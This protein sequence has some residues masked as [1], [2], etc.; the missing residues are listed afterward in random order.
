MV[1]CCGRRSRACTPLRTSRIPAT[2]PSPPRSPCWSRRTPQECLDFAKAGLS[3]SPRSIDTPVLLRLCTRIAHSQSIV[4]IQRAGR[5]LPQKPYIKNGAKYI[6][7]PGNAIPPPSRGGGQN[8]T[9]TPANTPETCPFNRMEMGRHTSWASSPPAPA[10]SMS[11]RSLETRVSVLKLGLINP[12]PDK[13]D[14][15]FCRIGGA[16]CGGGGAGRR[17]REP[18]ARHMGLS[19][20]ARKH[21]SLP[22]GEFSQNTIAQVCWAAHAKETAVHRDG[23]SPPVR[24]IMC[25]GCPHR[26]MFYVLWPRIR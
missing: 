23:H 20:S 1:V 6:M 4:E 5:I 8:A 12:M 2:T 15:G 26:G 11:R 16:A 9:A 18:T 3:S 22:L 10:T 19:L 7:M 14:P 17:H 21:R 25:A 24:P 13:H